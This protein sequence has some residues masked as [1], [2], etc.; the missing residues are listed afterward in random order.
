[1]TTAKKRAAWTLGAL[2]AASAAL[3]ALAFSPL[4]DV[5]RVDV[6]GLHHLTLDEVSDTL[7]FEPGDA[8][9]R[10]DLGAAAAALRGLPWVADARLTRTWRGVVTVA[11]TEHRPAALT[12]RSD[13]RWVLVSATGRVLTEPLA[14][15][16]ALPRL[17]GLRAAGKPGTHLEEHA[18]ALLAVVAALAPAA[19]ATPPG[20]RPAV[21][22]ESLWRDRRGDIRVNLATGDLATIG[23]DSELPAKVAALTTV[24]ERL[25]QAGDAAVPREIDVSVPH[26]PVVR[27][28]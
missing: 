19:P 5:E 4:A 6:V 22:V 15:P 21:E 10:L 26:L 3:A 24:L 20:G 27:R 17:S 25:E 14:A 13:E 16:P 1:M 8:L 23:D 2:V 7:G 11:V 12:L 28:R 9:V 18:D